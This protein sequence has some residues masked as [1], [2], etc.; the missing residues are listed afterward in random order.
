MTNHPFACA[1]PIGTTKFLWLLAGPQR[2][3]TND[4]KFKVAPV[5]YHSAAPLDSKFNTEVTQSEKEK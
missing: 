4:P 1:L 5:S 3:A 2:Q